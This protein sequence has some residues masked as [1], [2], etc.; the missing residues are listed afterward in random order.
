MPGSGNLPRSVSLL[1]C[2][3]GPTLTGPTSQAVTQLK[4]GHLDSSLGAAAQKEA[5]AGGLNVQVTKLATLLNRAGE[6]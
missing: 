5:L 2:E 4:R 3:I 1:I 6:F